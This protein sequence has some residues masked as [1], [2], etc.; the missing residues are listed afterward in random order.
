MNHS[1][2]FGDAGARRCREHGKSS[3][4]DHAEPEWLSVS[5]NR[6]NHMAGCANWSGC[7]VSFLTLNAKRLTRSKDGGKA[8]DF[9]ILLE[10]SNWPSL[11]AVTEVDGIS[12]KTDLAAELGKDICR[13]YH[14]R[15]SM[16]SVA[17][18]GISIPRSDKL[19][20]GGIALLVHRRLNVDIRDV[21]IPGVAKDDLKW[22][23]GHLRVYRLDPNTK[24]TT[25]GNKLAFLLKRP[26][27]VTVAYVPPHDHNGWGSKTRTALFA[28]MA[29]SDEQINLLCR[30]QGI[31]AVSFDHTNAPDDGCDLPLLVDAEVVNKVSALTDTSAPSTKRKTERATIRTLV[32]GSF[33]LQRRKHAARRLRKQ[34]KTRVVHGKEVAIAAARSNKVALAGV[35][36]ARQ[37]T[38][39]TAC[40]NCFRNGSRDVCHKKQCGRMRSCHDNV[41][42]P[43]NLIYEALM[44]PAG[45]RDLLRFRTRRIMWNEC[46]DHAVTSGFFFVH[47]VM[48]SNTAP[49]ETRVLQTVRAPRRQKFSQV[50]AERT[51]TFAFIRDNIETILNDSEPTDRTDINAHNAHIVDALQ[52]AT[53]RAP[54]HVAHEQA[55]TSVKTALR[56]FNRAWQANHEARRNLRC[57]LT[58]HIDE[59]VQQVTVR[60]LG[61]TLKLASRMLARARANE[62]ARH[63]ERQR[64]SAPSSAW[65]AMEAATMEQGATPAPLFKLCE[66]L[67]DDDGRLLTTDLSTIQAI[68]WDERQKVYQYR[69]HLGDECE[70]SIDDA[71]VG[72]S[73]QSKQTMEQ[74]PSCF[75]D[76]SFVAIS[77]ADM[78]APVKDIDRRRGYHRDLTD[79]LLRFQLHRAKGETRGE[80]TQRLFPVEC[81][82]LQCDISV[83]EVTSVFEKQRDTG[84]GID[85]QAPV[86]LK[87]LSQGLVPA[88]VT[89][90]LNEVWKTGI[91]PQQWCEHRCLLHYK[92]KNSDPCCLSNYRGLGIDQ[93]LLK[94][95][96]LVMN[97]R[98]IQFLEKTGGLS[99]SQGGFQR[100]R[101]TPE[102]VFT[103]AETVRAALHQT[104]V[105]LVFIDIE[106]AYDSVL[107][108]ILWQKCIDRG[109]VGRFLAVLQAIYHRAVV[110]LE[111]AGERLPAMPIESGVMQGNPLSPALFNIYIDDAIRSL[112]EYGHSQE[113]R[114]WG[115]SLPR[116]NAGGNSSARFA[117]AAQTQDDFLMSLFFA[118][119]GVLMEF[120]IKRLQIMLNVLKISLARIG[121]LLN[122]GK[123][124]WLIVAK[125]AILGLDSPAAAPVE[126]NEQ[127]QHEKNSI[128]AVHHLNIDGKPVKLVDY[129]DYL[130]VMMSWRWS[131]AAAWRAATQKAHYRLYCMQRGGFQHSGYSLADQLTFVRGKVACHFNYIAA[132]TG[133]GGINNQTQKKKNTAPW[134]SAEAVMSRALCAIVDFPFANS[135]VLKIES[136]TWDQQTR[137]AMLLLRFAYK[138]TTMDHNSTMYRA[139]CLSIQTLSQAQRAAP[140]AVYAHDSL[141]HYQPWAQQLVASRR[142]FGLPD[143]DPLNVC[144][145]AVEVYVDMNKT[146]AFV[147]LTSIIQN[148]TPAQLQVLDQFFDITRAPIRLVSNLFG[149]TR[150][151]QM[152][153]GVTCWT[154]PS[155]VPVSALLKV[156]SPHLQLACYAALKQRGNLRRQQ[157]V[158]AFID[159]IACQVDKADQDPTATGLGTSSRRWC[160][161]KTASYLEPY[162]FLPDCEK[163]RRLL[164]VRLDCMPNED[165]LRRRPS[166]KTLP[167]S[168]ANQI[169]RRLRTPTIYPRLERPLRACY[170]CAGID[171]T[172]APGV[173]WA[174][175]LEHLLLR[176]PA[177]SEL[178]DRLRHKLQELVT[179][180]DTQ[181]V[182]QAMRL[183]AVP[184]FEHEISTDHDAQIH[185]TMWIV[186][187]LATGVRDRDHV[188]RW[189]GRR[190]PI[191]SNLD[192]PCDIANVTSRDIRWERAHLLRVS[193]EFQ[194]HHEAACIATGWVRALCDDWL[195]HIRQP[196]PDVET[197]T[198]PGARLVALVADFIWDAFGARRKFVRRSD[199][200]L[201]RRRD[202]PRSDDAATQERSDESIL[203]VRTVRT[204]H[205][206]T[207]RHK[208]ARASSSR[209]R[210]ISSRNRLLAQRPATVLEAPPD[211][212][213]PMDP[214]PNEPSPDIP[215]PVTRSRRKAGLM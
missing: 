198:R 99:Q 175:S 100:R 144:M 55:T 105:N 53:S 159:G 192:A 11:V 212:F 204:A 103:L 191:V 195:N 64:T 47:P 184:S 203:R 77:S 66:A 122:V 20:G 160:E 25:K 86:V 118:D 140:C 15:Y 201:H 125:L 182:A 75:D 193:P 10:Q 59:V 29:A 65:E 205:G 171:E 154:A 19:V 183:W 116:V 6:R 215:G 72:V 76:R 46:I 173:Y 9:A 63:L 186:V 172:H 169:P 50:L 177:Y 70:A 119:D 149:A 156:W 136:G 44:S 84:P 180:P 24:K 129:F 174:E 98:L 4:E 12:G 108:P 89:R 133:A 26:M 97:N 104:S 68:A 23:D 153:D 3:N 151:A 208:S 94:V 146:G 141:L 102:Q 81:Q 73:A 92:G 71:L 32:D 189:R 113:G 202:P 78:A 52:Q 1:R 101:G 33:I 120:D 163:G 187:R 200:Y 137:I 90:L 82:Q 114:C 207:R 62:R 109:I 134:L 95:L 37:S 152:L 138:L 18:D 121:L 148:W 214:C 145:D 158:R 35:M 85:G 111:L 150:P 67:H 126:T 210:Q 110:T 123:T 43:A 96:S 31:F 16:R 194:Y 38:S 28:A 41:R 7:R 79:A 42:V 161:L 88:E 135:D 167:A 60:R 61:K 40:G 22:M 93:L 188:L 2:R 49:L 57:K 51:N 74:F 131:W 58:P 178:R 56:V 80:Q 165:Y 8:A 14:L 13:R 124:K 170:L 132:V 34:D 179:A 127:Y 69:Q 143:L 211:S 36:G 142:W 39:W 168:S 130:G 164:R 91:M 128:V 83:D 87:L 30:T 48:R 147:P 185:T 106:R 112:D 166:R 45:G 213:V 199:D 209:R 27:Y 21:N 17:L 196:L 181:A 107:H 190:M 176:C 117:S 5:R 206:G 157:L 54:K 115:L 139:M 155:K 197:S 162:W